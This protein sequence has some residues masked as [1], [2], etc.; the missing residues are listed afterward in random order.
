MK[1]ILA[2][3]VIA[4]LFVI[5]IRADE[6]YLVGITVGGLY[7]NVEVAGNNDFN[8]N[9]SGISY[10][11][12]W[13]IG[14]VFNKRIN[15]S[16]SLETGLY[17]SRRGYDQEG[18]YLSYA[19]GYGNYLVNYTV[20]NNYNYIDIP[21]KIKYSKTN[22]QPY[23]GWNSCI[24]IGGES[25]MKN[26]NEVYGSSIAIYK[27]KQFS[28]DLN[29]G[30]LLG[31]TYAFG[32]YFIDSSYYIGVSD[33]ANENMSMNIYHRTLSFNVGMYLK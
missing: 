8:P 16:F 32:K 17:Y 21:V 22:L 13:N 4:L 23:F 25:K 14:T 10:N 26:R 6:N 30:V 24:L 15:S 2:I 1:K 28:K 3:I 7:N 12:G 19:E 31:I 18:R 9:H 20:I 29:Y 27:I 5:N 33:S 11:I